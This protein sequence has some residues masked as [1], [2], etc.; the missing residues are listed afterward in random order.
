MLLLCLGAVNWHPSVHGHRLR[1]FNH[2]YIWLNAYREAVVTL[3]SM[4]TR[5]NKTVESLMD[6]L[7]NP[8]ASTAVVYSHT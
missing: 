3:Y 7:V 1:A 8:E 5:E 6:Q 2:V 4:I